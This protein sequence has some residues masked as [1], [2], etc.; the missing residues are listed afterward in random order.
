[1]T[2][3]ADYLRAGYPT[4]W[5]NTLEPDRAEREL[6]KLAT[7][8]KG[9][10]PIR[11]D[12]AQGF[13]DMQDGGHK[14]CP[15]PAKAI[16]MAAS[17]PDKTT[18]FLWNFHRLLGSLEVVQAVQNA[19]RELK[20]K[21]NCL[22][23][24]APSADKL[25]E[26]LA[27]VYTTLEFELPDRA[28]LHQ[29]M[30][31]VAEPYKIQVP[32]QDGALIDAALGLT[33]MEAEDAFALS[34]VTKKGFD[35]EVIA[36][37][38]ARA[39]LRQSQLQL[40]RFQE[41]FS[42]LGGLDVLKEYTLKT[43]VSPMAQGIL[44]MGVP[45]TGKSSFCKALANELSIPCLSLDFGRMMGSLVGQSEANIRNALKAVDAMGRCVL[46]IDEIEA[47]LA[48]VKSSG[49]L[50]SG[51]KAGVGGTFLKWLSD[52]QPGR[53]YLVATANSINLPP[54]Y[55]RSERWDS[56]WFVDLPNRE[57]KIAIWGIYLKKY[58]LSLA[59]MIDQERADPV[60]D[61][62]GWTGSD[63]RACC[64]TAAMMQCSTKEA[65]RYIVPVTKSMGEQIEALRE[66]A[67][68]RCVLASRPEGR[69]V[70]GRRLAVYPSHHYEKGT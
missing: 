36:E 34:L 32:K 31:E 61:D 50:D 13:T 64:R 46:F 22:V 3:F 68:G 38:K 16:E 24:L 30:T 42:D 53:A 5:V 4:L 41:R 14:P 66:W 40:N 10:P 27:R 20:A 65:A 39:L 19:V 67:K 25:P 7:E 33:D 29:A 57:E 54:Q 48:G 59:G 8:V 70:A 52:R 56:L 58:G 51:T 60:P 69:A 18:V 26:E 9:I 1:M 23:V 55:L 43:A 45:G 35:A 44:I 62:A 21:G 47:G 2:N 37:Q 11:W 6:G 28:S 17:M 12:V 15:S 63:I 49:E